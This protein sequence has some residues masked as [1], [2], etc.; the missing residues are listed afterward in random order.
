MKKDNT[1]IWLIVLAVLTL[2][3]CV[4]NEK[5]H[6]ISDYITYDTTFKR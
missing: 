6:S 2:A 4:Y 5:T 1:I 3:F